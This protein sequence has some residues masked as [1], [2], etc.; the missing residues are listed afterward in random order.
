[1]S[2]LI[3]INDFQ[4]SKDLYFNDFPSNISLEVTNRCNLKCT[5]CHHSYRKKMSTGDLSL[6]IF[7]KL[8]PYLGNKIQNISLNGLG[9]PL[10]SDQWDIIYKTCIAKNNLTV[11]FI[12]NGVLPLKIG[13]ELLRENLNITFSL[14]GAS[15][16]I[17]KKI[18]RTDVFDRVI[19][20]VKA[21]DDYKKSKNSLCPSLGAI[22]VVTA[23]NA[24]EMPEFVRLAH[25]IGISNVTFSH[26]V[27]HFES[28]LINE[29]AFFTPE[30]HDQ[31]LMEAQRQA[32]KLDIAVVHMGTFNKPVMPGCAGDNWLYKN[33]DGGI[34]CGLIKNWCMVNYTG[35][36]QVCCAP[37]SLI[38]GDLRENSLFEIWNGAVYRKLKTGLS[39]SFEK[40][41]GDM[42]N[43]KQS[44]SLDDIRAFFC[45]LYETY[46]YNP[47][48]AIKQAYIITDLNS[49]YDSAVKALRKG[50][51]S[52]AIEKC[53]LVLNIEPLTFEAENLKGIAF[54]LS[55]EK[56]KAAHCFLRSY[57][58]CKDYKTSI[59]NLQ[60]L[61]K[62]SSGPG[63]SPSSV[64]SVLQS[65]II[66][67][68]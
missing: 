36:I 16:S 37:D 25:K 46:D 13:P 17:Y 31:Y 14:D 59:A 51:L 42:C 61:A 55:G 6:G 57:T 58:I 56:E 20:H 47:H 11:S 33:G 43:L 35:H 53:A 39:H 21:I 60:A 41:C 12:T 45:K 23:Q 29:S 38:A 18:R 15:S 19:S 3:N 5:H 49:I 28:Q 34:R 22:F 24:H 40:T 44:L 62:N 30:E 26:L 63:P 7:E 52:S 2:E 66:S 1:M 64:S 9:E 8:L 68:H 4:C 27:A 54:A 50:D 65:G 48:K 67:G 32:S 10:M